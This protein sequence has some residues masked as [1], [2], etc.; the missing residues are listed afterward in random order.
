MGSREAAKAAIERSI[1]TA[2]IVSQPLGIDQLSDLHAAVVAFRNGEYADAIW[3][4]QNALYADAD[5]K[6]TDPKLPP[7]VSQKLEAFYDSLHQAPVFHP[8]AAE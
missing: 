7:T 2:K 8:L 6:L 3:F 5:R 1:A 4:A